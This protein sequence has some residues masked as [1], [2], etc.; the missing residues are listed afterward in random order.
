MPCGK[1]ICPS[2]GEQPFLDE[3]WHPF[4]RNRRNNYAFSAGD[5]T[6]GIHRSQTF[7]GMFN[8]QSPGGWSDFSAISDGLS[9]TIAMS[10]KLRQGHSNTQVAAVQDV[11][12]RRVVAI[13]SNVGNEPIRAMA[14]H[15]GNYLLE[16][17]QYQRKFG[18]VSHHGNQL[19]TVFTTVLPPNGPSAR[20]GNV[21]LVYTASSNHPGGVNVLMGDGAIRFVGNT[22]DTGNLGVGTLSSRGGPSRYGVWGA[23]GSRAG[24]DSG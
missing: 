7:R 21:G 8:Q 16:G 13:V 6:R 2:D 4:G 9:N 24:G 14:V 5:A 1:L 12:M 20:D 3:P 17:T 19:H 15:D 18:N 22:I 11:N 23:L 10:E